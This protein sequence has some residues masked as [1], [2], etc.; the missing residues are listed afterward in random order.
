[1]ARQIDVEVQRIL[2]E[3]Y[4]RAK[5]RLAEQ[6]D[7][8]RDAAQALLA[9]ETLSGEELAT[10]VAAHGPLKPPARAA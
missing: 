3:Q 4:S 7:L 6:V 5:A 8:I 2:D 9:K 1:V 10:L